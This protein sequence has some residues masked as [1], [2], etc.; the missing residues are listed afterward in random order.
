MTGQAADGADKDSISV[1]GVD[2]GSVRGP[3]R[4]G[5][6][7]GWFTKRA[8]SAVCY[9]AAGNYQRHVFPR[10]FPVYPPTIARAI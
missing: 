5:Q 3:V 6:G 9:V 1:G 10:S 2:V 8:I 4:A 7:R